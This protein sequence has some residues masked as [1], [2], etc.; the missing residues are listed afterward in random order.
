[1][2]SEVKTYVGHENK[3]VMRPRFCY[4]HNSQFPLQLDLP[5]KEIILEYRISEFQCILRDRFASS[6]VTAA[7]S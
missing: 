3:I 4:L 6:Q 7:H 5:F 1:M 2:F